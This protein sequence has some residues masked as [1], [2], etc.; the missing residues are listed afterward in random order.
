MM[1]LEMRRYAEVVYAVDIN[2][3]YLEQI[4]NDGGIVKVVSDAA[5]YFTKENDFDVITIFG[6]IQFNTGEEVVTIYDNCYRMLKPGGVLIISGQWGVEEKVIVDKFSEELQAKFFSEYRTTDE[7]QRT[8]AKIGFESEV[9]TILPE[10]FN[11][12]TDTRFYGIV[13]QK[14]PMTEKSDVISR[15]KR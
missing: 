8:L 14:K 5:E 7:E 9:V 13:A 6:A 12:Y 11:R 10:R 1:S 4:P 15:D 2:P 3:S